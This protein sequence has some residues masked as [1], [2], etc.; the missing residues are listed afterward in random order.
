MMQPTFKGMYDS[1]W[2]PAY[3]IEAVLL[4]LQSFLFEPLPED[5]EKIKGILINYAIKEANDFKCPLC[6]HRGPLSAYPPFPKVSGDKDFIMVKT[7]K[8]LLGE[9]LVC[10]QTKAPLKEGT[11]GI[12]I[13]LKKSPRTGLCM[14]VNPTLDLLNM[15]SFTKL[16]IRAD[17][18]KKRFTHWLPL[19]FGENEKFE[20]ISKDWDQQAGDMVETKKSVDTFERFEKHIK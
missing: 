9:E 7:E 14:Y 2:V 1:G 4:Q 16:K 15:R 12:G 19:Y 20:I 18:N 6:K 5:I 11:L 3:T 17:M 13:S 8:Q 10:T